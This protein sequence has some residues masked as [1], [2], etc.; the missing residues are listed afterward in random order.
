M[1]Q[2][3][4]S[5]LASPDLESRFRQEDLP[6]EKRSAAAVLTLAAVFQLASVATDLSLLG[7]SERLPAVLGLRGFGVVVAFVALLWIRGN[8]NVQAFDQVLSLW[9][10]LLF[11]GVI[12]ANAMLPE[13]YTEY[14]AWDLLLAFGAYT[15]VPVPLRRQAILAGF[16]TAGSLGVA[17]GLKSFRAPAAI[18]DLAL[19][20]V[21]ANV[22]GFSTSWGLHRA[23]RRQFVAHRAEREARQALEE[24][25]SEIRILQGI[26]PICASCKNVRTDEG[27]WE[28]VEAY[29]RDH[30]EAEFSHGIC[31]ECERILYPEDE[32]TGPAGNGGELPGTSG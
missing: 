31:P 6:R 12:A 29:V 9:A 22:L 4:S 2:S 7:G 30:S 19:A 3:F 24:A 28:Q 5:L 11:G 13:D 26:I 15:V 27:T 10:T 8:R 21:C 18:P 17:W 25:R 32:E 20:F 1:F 16:M 14:V 23:R